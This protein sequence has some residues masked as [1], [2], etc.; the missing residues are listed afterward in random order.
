MS[1]QNLIEAQKRRIEL[2]LFDAAIE[3]HLDMTERIFNDNKDI[4][5]NSPNSYDTI[6]ASF[7][8][9]SIP[10]EAGKKSK[11]GKTRYFAGGY[12]EM[13]S[14]VGKPPLQLFGVLQNSWNNSLRQN[15][16]YE[17]TMSVPTEDANKIKGNFK[18]FFRASQSELNKFKL[19]VIKND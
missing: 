17:F 11:S 6:P 2:N 13:K 12:A 16:P 9:K 15:N 1:V 5:G 4:N 3:L 18:N 19:N 14:A 8:R 7:S 10:R